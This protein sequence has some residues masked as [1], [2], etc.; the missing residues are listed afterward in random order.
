MPLS[1]ITNKIKEYLQQKKIFDVFR[2][3]ELSVATDMVVATVKRNRESIVQAQRIADY[4][5]SKNELYYCSYGRRYLAIVASESDKDLL[6]RAFGKDIV[7]ISDK[8]GMIIIQSPY[9]VNQVPGIIAYIGSIFSSRN[10]NIIEF[11]TAN[12]DTLILIDE[13]D[14]YK[15]A[16]VLKKIFGC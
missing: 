8:V 11:F 1:G 16:D 3:S 6:K 7:N 12:D 4:L 15:M 5:I 2:Q 14:A 13:K 9:E 10:V